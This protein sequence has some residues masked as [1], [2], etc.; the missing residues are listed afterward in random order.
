MGQVG[1]AAFQVPKKKEAGGTEQLVPAQ[2]SPSLGGRALCLPFC[3]RREL[4]AAAGK[5]AIGVCPHKATNPSR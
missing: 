1:E 5:F 2:S 3:V 4:E